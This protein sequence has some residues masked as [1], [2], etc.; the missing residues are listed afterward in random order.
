M[1]FW[2]YAEKEYEELSAESIKVL[3]PFATTDDCEAGFSYL[4]AIKTKYRSQ[5]QP[6]HDMH[7]CLST[8]FPRIDEL[9]GK[10]Q[11]Q[12]SHEVG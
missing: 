12:G 2:L 8:I 3:L 10:I 11:A 5:L 4:T 9:V 7:A 1:A 6:E